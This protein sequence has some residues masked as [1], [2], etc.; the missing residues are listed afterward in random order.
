MKSLPGLPYAISPRLAISLI[1]LMR[2]II[3]GSW[4]PRIPGIAEKLDIPSS[5]LGLVWFTAA[6]CNILAFSIAA[7]LVRRFGTATTQLFFAIPYPLVYMLAGFAPTFPLFWLAILGTGLAGGG[8]DI[9]TSVQGGIVERATKRPLVSALYG[10]FSLGALIGSFISGLVAQAGVPMGVQFAV[11]S[12]VAIPASLILRSGLLPDEKRPTAPAAKRRRFALPSKALLPLGITIICVALGEET[13]NNWVALYMRSDLGSDPA[14]AGFAYTA[15]AVATFTGRIL[16]DRVISRIGV[17]RVI[18]GGAVL[19][20]GGVAFGIIVNQPWSMV[21]G[22]TV[23]GAGLSVMVPV[24]YRRAGE[25][26]GMSPADAVSQV[27]SIGFIG[28]MVGPVLIGLLSDLISLRFVLALVALVLLGI[29]AMVRL[30]PSGE[31]V[32]VQDRAPR[33]RPQPRWRP[34]GRLRSNAR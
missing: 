33:M 12:A 31:L 34:R 32:T 28:F 29:V 20:A 19:A 21:A 17:D 26:P 1:F 9:S 4:F 5:Q 11:I 6:A 15:F 16:G 13:I 24:T 3:L 7:R 2:G 25:T 8:Y 10:Y 23:V 30:S 18:T 22:Y 14:I 27:A